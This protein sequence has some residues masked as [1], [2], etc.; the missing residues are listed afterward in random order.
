KCWSV[1]CQRALIISPGFR[2]WRPSITSKA[3]DDH[4]ASSRNSAQSLYLRVSKQRKWHI[5]GDSSGC[6]V[7]PPIS[8]QKT[9]TPQQHSCNAHLS[10]AASRT[11]LDCAS[12]I[13]AR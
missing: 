7:E 1:A 10:Q 9:S 2:S 8:S 12:S 13:E 6:D 5:D 11:W 3:L 4:S